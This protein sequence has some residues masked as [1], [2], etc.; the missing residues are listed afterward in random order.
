VN[1]TTLVEGY[2]LTCRTEGKSPK[3]CD[4]Y[5]RFLHRFGTYLDKVQVVDVNDIQVDHVRGFLDAL[6]Q[7][8]KWSTH[9]HVPTQDETIVHI[10]YT[11]MGG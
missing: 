2:L 5:L 10:Q 8:K 9:V 3:T 4:L 6:A 1:F 11:F 7:T